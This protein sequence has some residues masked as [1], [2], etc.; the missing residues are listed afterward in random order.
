MAQVNFSIKKTVKGEPSTIYV[1]YFHGRSSDQVTTTGLTVLPDYWSNK[2]QGIKPNVVYGSLFTA[3]HA[4]TLTTQLNELRAYILREANSMPGQEL[5]AKWLKNLVTAHNTPAPVP[6][7][8]AEPAKE[9]FNAFLSRFYDE[10]K[11]GKALCERGNM[12]V[13]FP[14][15]SL[16]GWKSFREIMNT[17]QQERG[18]TLNFEDFDR[19]F[20]NDFVEWL[21]DRNLTANYVG[22]IIKKL[23][24]ILR[25]AEEHEPPLHSNLEY[26]KRYFKIMTEEIDPVYLTK[27]EIAA[28]RALDL[29]LDPELAAVRDVFLVGCY[30]GQRYSDYS[31]IGRDNVRTT[32]GRRYVELKQRKTGA[33]VVIPVTVELDEILRRY[34]NVLPRIHE[35]E[36]NSSIKA[37]AQRA[38]I[39]DNVEV[40]RTKGGHKG[41]ANKPKYKLISSHTARRTA[42]T[43][44]YLDGINEIDLMKLSG[45]ASS[46]QLLEYISATPDQTAQRLSLHKAFAPL[47]VAR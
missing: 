14:K 44:W 47:R 41:Q 28:L 16:R 23:K 17:Y 12:V 32:G 34:D 36:L 6:V 39:L 8:E 27:E 4:E 35:N 40:T 30:T 22:A 7:A 42:L 10:A 18:I 20:Y 21:N 45:H 25:R 38:K 37:I 33:R 9:D 11:A 3:E 46:K 15:S 19:A 5:P 13:A 24:N 29:S 31:R 1:R 43:N 26:K 2:K